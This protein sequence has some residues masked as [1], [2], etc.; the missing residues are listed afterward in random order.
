MRVTRSIT[1]LL[2]PTTR[3]N[4]PTSDDASA[5]REDDESTNLMKSLTTTRTAL[6]REKS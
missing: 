3:L 6:T 4:P 1:P 2:T 5:E